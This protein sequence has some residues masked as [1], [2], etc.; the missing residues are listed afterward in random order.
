MS[1]CARETSALRVYEET[2]PDHHQKATGGREIADHEAI[3]SVSTFRPDWGVEKMR[4]NNPLTYWQSDCP[5]PKAPHTVDLLFHQATFIKQVSIF[6]DYTQ[7]DSYTP[8]SISIRGGTTYRDLH[9]VMALEC[10]ET[11]GWQN[12]DL[13]FRLQIA[14]LNTHLNG[15]DTH[16]RQVKVYSV[17]P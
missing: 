9:E 5:N 8:K 13:F 4:D 2:H 3:W 6:I 17:L 16:I 7:D 1:D 12:A 10:P 11:V 15:R 14:V